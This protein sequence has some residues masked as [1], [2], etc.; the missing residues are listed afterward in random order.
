MDVRKR[1]PGFALEV[2]ASLR[3]GVTAIFGPSGSGKTTLLNCVAGLTT[4]DEGRIAVSGRVLFSSPARVN[5]PPE[6]RRLG[7]V[8]QDGLLFPHLSVLGNIR[9]GYRLT[10]PRARRIEPEQ[11]AELLGLGGL[12]DR[13][14]GTLSGGE[15]Q[16]VALARALATS[17]ELLL[18]DEPLASLDSHL[19]GVIL[20]YLR[21]VRAELGTSM[22]YVSHS[23]SEVMALADDV[24]VIAGG[25]QV[26]FGPPRRIVYDPAVFPLADEEE[27][28][29][30]LEAE[31]VR[32]D[33]SLRLTE[34]R[35]GHE[36]LLLPLL[37]RQPGEKVA[38]ALRASDP[39]ISLTRPEQMSAQNLLRGCIE[40]IHT[41]GRRAFVYVDVGTLL[42]VQVGA[43]A[44]KKLDLRE[45][46]QVY[47]ILKA[48]GA[49]VLE[50]A[51]AWTR[52]APPD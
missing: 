34:A 52:A 10:P 14:V 43:N 5:V 40:G 36:R 33:P 45:G 24:L 8:F 6:R 13:R 47:L 50:Q 9:Y 4:P 38:L 48:T 2:N 46:L 41:V 32:H 3:R 51:P 31:V 28:E 12:L 22:L 16:R 37:D 30:I 23:V 26:A 25:R 19:K 39:I 11:V 42:A 17:P 49:M 21:R 20:T 1:F 35:L 7:Y 44:V 27:M 18:L 29:N 15:Q